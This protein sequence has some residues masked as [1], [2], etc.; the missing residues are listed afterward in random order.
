MLVVLLH[1]WIM[2]AWC[3]EWCM[4]PSL[5]MHVLLK[6]WWMHLMVLLMVVS[7]TLTLEL[8]VI[9]HGLHVLHV[10]HVHGLLVRCSIHVAHHGTRHCRYLRP[11]C[12]SMCH[13]MLV[14]HASRSARCFTS[15]HGC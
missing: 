7:L 10:L 2:K 6:L 3:H 14:C 9:L 4:L 5:P 12:M 11:M 8:W 13:G 1:G 15:V